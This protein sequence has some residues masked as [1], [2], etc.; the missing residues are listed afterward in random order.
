MVYQKSIKLAPHR[1]IVSSRGAVTYGVAKV[2]AKVLKPLVG[3]CPHHIQNTRDFVN[4]LKGLLSYHRSALCS[5]DVTAL[6]TTVPID[7]ALA[8]IKDLLE[9]G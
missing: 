7:P 4:R 9:Q 1:P 6:L 3:K 2:L 8:I 5:Y